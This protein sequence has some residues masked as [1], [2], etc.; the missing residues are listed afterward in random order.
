MELEIIRL[1]LKSFM[2]YDKESLLDRAIDITKEHAK[3]KSDRLPSVVLEEVYNKLKELNED[4][5]NG[6]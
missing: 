1:N 6:S 3:G 5:K 4:T 2:S